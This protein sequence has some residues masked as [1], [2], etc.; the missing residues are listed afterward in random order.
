MITEFLIWVSGLSLLPSGARFYAAF[1][2]T[3]VVAPFLEEFSK[4]FP[5]FYRH[6][7]IVESIVTLGFL[8]G[9]GFGMFEFCTYVFLLGV[10]ILS[11]LS[12][13]LFH[14]AITSI[15]A[16]GIATKRTGVF[17]LSAVTLHA[18]NNI[19]AS[20]I[21]LSLNSSGQVGPWI[22][23][24]PFPTLIVFLCLVYIY[25]KASEKTRA[26]KTT[27]FMQG[28]CGQY[29]LE[30]ETVAYLQMRLHKWCGQNEQ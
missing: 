8:V 28:L 21:Y 17:Y 12:G 15:T 9:L 6:G 1:I 23:A 13:I 26:L 24:A 20:L 19:L 4:A 22:I 16:Y 11:R 30:H 27:A 14:S 18:S 2:P 5:L 7:E 25:W 3:V 10:P 29:T